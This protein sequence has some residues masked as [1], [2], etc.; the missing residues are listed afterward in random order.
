LGWTVGGGGSIRMKRT[1]VGGSKMSVGRSIF[2]LMI[3]ATAAMCALMMNSNV[4]GLERRAPI[5]GR[6]AA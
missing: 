3:A 4:F 6:P 5:L 1:T 2:A